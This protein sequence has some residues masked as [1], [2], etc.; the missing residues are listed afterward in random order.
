MTVAAQIRGRV[1]DSNR[2][3]K[4]PS[5]DVNAVVSAVTSIYNKAYTLD[6]LR[7]LARSVDEGGDHR[8]DLLASTCVYGLFTS[9]KSF[10]NQGAYLAAGSYYK[11]L[12]IY[13]YRSQA[14]LDDKKALLLNWAERVGN[15]LVRVGRLSDAEF[16]S[17]LRTCIMQQAA[18]SQETDPVHNILQSIAA[19][20]SQTG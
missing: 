9:L 6:K 15:D 18:N 19:F 11:E 10:E 8:F 1:S 2:A 3:Y 17:T 14:S 16:R 4:L 12:E 5:S 20:A 13:L 7:L